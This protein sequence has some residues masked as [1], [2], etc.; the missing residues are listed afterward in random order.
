MAKILITAPPLA[1]HLNPALAVAER[2]QARGHEIAWA[3][4]DEAIGDL[5]PA[6]AQRFALPLDAALPSKQNAGAVRG[7]ESV[8]FFYEDFCLP[9]A[10]IT[11]R[12]LERIARAYEPDFMLC[13]HQM[14][15]GALVARQLNIPW[16]SSVTTTASLLKM[17]PV[18]EEWLASQLHELQLLYRATQCVERPDISPHGALVFSS[19]QLLGDKFER[20]GGT[21]HFVG[22]AFSGRV[23]NAPFDWQLLDTHKRKILISLGTVS[24]DRGVRFYEVMMQA[25]AD[26]DVQVIMVAPPEMAASA[27][28]NFIVRSRVPQV[29]LLPHLDAV[30]CHAG[31]NTVC[32]ALSFGLP[33]IVAPI[34]DDQPV[35]ARQVIDAGAG[36]FMRFGKVTPATA[37]ATIEQLLSDT[38]FKTN[39]QQLAQ[40]FP[41]LG[42]AARA[43]VLIEQLLNEQPI[44]Q[45]P[46]KQQ[47]DTAMLAGDRGR[48]VF[49]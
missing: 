21:H 19:E 35:I 13:D 47:P 17:T 39:A 5:L 29:E 20:I 27:P 23:P 3:V 16:L 30:I 11:L 40:S 34:R 45:M 1:G 43:A 37:R 12:P 26:L 2:L 8:R 6:H 49:H 36:L 14:L 44:K 4:Q 31:H 46:N 10:R 38:S 24:R 18:M 15:A 9:M 42:G 33:L 48:H 32:E 28:R 41:G 25:L 22:P 7:L